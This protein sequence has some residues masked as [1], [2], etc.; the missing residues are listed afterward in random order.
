MQ[1]KDCP[2][3]RANNLLKGDVIAESSSAYLIEN[4]FAPG[5]YLIIPNDHAESIASLSDTWWKDVKELVANIP[6]PLTEYNLSMNIGRQAG[7][8]V[9]HV[10]LW[11]IPRIAGEASSGKGLLALM[12]ESVASNDKKRRNR[13]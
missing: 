2:F 10:H 4:Q 6:D 12:D 9:K 8:S 3:C 1:P 13:E 11:I 5:N 7:Q